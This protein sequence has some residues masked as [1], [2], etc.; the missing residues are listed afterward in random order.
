MGP[1]FGW[2]TRKEH[3]PYILATYFYQASLTTN[4]KGSGYGADLGYKF[5]LRKLSLGLQI[6]YRHYDFNKAGSASLSP[7]Y[8]KQTIDPEIALLFE[9]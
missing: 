7:A 6:S 1:S 8:T 4:L 5:S 9:F 3:G 2:L